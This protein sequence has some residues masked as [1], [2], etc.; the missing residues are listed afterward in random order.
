MDRA[1]S[2]NGG[3]PGTTRGVESLTVL[4]RQ[5]EKIEVVRYVALLSNF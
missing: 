5:A 2:D 4:S 1:P 3:V